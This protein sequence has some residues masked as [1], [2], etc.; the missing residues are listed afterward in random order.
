M[1]D[2]DLITLVEDEA[3]DNKLVGLGI[4][5]P[6]LTRAL[7]KCRRGRLTPFGWWHVLRAIKYHKTKV[8][9]LLLIGVLPEYRMKG[10]NSLLFADLIP[11][12]QKD[13]F[14]WGETQ[15]EME[16]NSK[17]QSQWEWLDA[18]IHKRRKCYIKTI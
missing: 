1:A 16:T 15:V 2:L 9:D 11:R 6:S 17:V 8:V 4:S 5:I 18:S 12:Y 13:G 14:E 3:A 10:V 7:Q